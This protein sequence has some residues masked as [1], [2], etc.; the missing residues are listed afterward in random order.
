MTLEQRIEA[1]E[2]E[3]AAL[4]GS[5]SKLLGD[6]DKSKTTCPAGIESGRALFTLPDCQK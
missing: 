4:K 1:L 3:V 5:V 6:N 2:K